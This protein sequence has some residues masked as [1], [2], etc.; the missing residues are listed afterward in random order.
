MFLLRS[1]VL[2]FS[3]GYLKTGSFEQTLSA[4]P[5]CSHQIFLTPGSQNSLPGVSFSHEEPRWQDH[6]GEKKKKKRYSGFRV[7]QILL[8]LG[9]SSFCREVSQAFLPLLNQDVP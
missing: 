1:F 3:P 2:L 8:N 6:T 4:L 9:F 5:V 7:N